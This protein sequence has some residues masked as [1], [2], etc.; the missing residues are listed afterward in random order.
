VYPI[1]IAVPN[2]DHRL[3]PGMPVD[4]KLAPSAH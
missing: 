3:R 1:E 4:V 2:R